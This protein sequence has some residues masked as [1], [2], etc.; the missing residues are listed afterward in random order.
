MIRIFIIILFSIIFVFAESP[1]S[2]SVY[3]GGLKFN[4]SKKT[5]G[6]VAGVYVM[7]FD[8]P[9]KVEGDVEHT[10]IN[11]KD[12]N[13]TI[14][15]TDYTLL[16]HF[17]KGYNYSYKLGVHKIHTTDALTKDGV[18]Y[19]LGAMYYK[20]GKY[21]LKFNSYYSDYSNLEI[22][23]KVIQASPEV[24]F[25]YGSFYL[26]KPAFYISMK[27][28]YIHPISNRKENNLK[29]SYISSSINI[30]NHFDKFTTVFNKWYGKRVLA[31]ENEGFIVHNTID[32]ELG[33]F[34]LSENYQYDKNQH[35]KF[36]Y[37]YMTFQ[38]NENDKISNSNL[39]L[40]SYLYNF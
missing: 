1:I 32:E 24:G 31:V 38:E 2:V 37:S 16:L 34:L 3:G 20:L 6:S 33:G 25:T 23:P 21:A 10:N 27:L 36:S 29:S 28:D 40:L 9:L 35:F 19:A 13:D 8:S 14:K 18:I 26:K 30:V 5:S 22:S 12:N 39:F 7:G 4:H 11:Q 17:F 15:Q